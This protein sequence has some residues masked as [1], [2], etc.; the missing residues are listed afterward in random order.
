MDE[1]KKEKEKDSEKGCEEG[2]EEV[3]VCVSGPTLTTATSSVGCE[4]RFFFNCFI[5]FLIFFISL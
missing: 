4:V 3:I 5:F 1:K 2:G